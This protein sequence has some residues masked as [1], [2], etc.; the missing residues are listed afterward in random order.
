MA[1]QNT[2]ALRDLCV[3]SRS[4]TYGIVQPGK[5]HDGGVPIVRV[6]NFRGH[7][8]DLSDRLH[9]A[10][11]IEANYR[12]SR[13]KPGD[14]LISLVGSIGQVAI[15]P[16]DIEGWNLARA[17]GLVPMVDQATA[18]WVY[19]AL[20]TQDAQDYIRRHA[21]T[22]VQATFNLKDLARFPIP[23]PNRREREQ[24]L[25]VLGS[26]DDK[27]ELNR[28]MNE[29][30]ERIAQAIFRDWFVDFGPTQRKLDGV[31]D[32]VEIM[33]GLIAEPDRAREL[34]DLFPARLG[35]DGPPEGWRASAI[36]NLVREAQNGGTPSRKKNEFWETAQ[37]AWFK[38]GELN[39]Q[40]LL[41]SEEMISESGLR[42]IGNKIWPRGTIL[43][44]IYASPTVGRMGVLT[45]DASANQACTALLPK[46]E[47]GTA[48]LFEILKLC[49][50]T[51]QN[52]AVGAAQQNISQKMLLEHEVL[53]P[54]PELVAS[55]S[56]LATPLLDLRLANQKQTR[57][58]AAT[59]DLLLPKL[60]S[61]EI[62]LR[63]AEVE[64]EAAQ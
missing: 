54:T 20:Q 15:A 58:L 45:G 42:A 32:P 13:P 7:R 34:A 61:G 40:F 19:Y 21:N 60:M 6:N 5:L 39:D 4:I 1:D 24:V 38:T 12:R 23:F 62:R 64:L 51:L 35:D 16:P 31:T 55:F 22:T 11:E 28:R 25:E 49:R 59:R 41:Q 26:L 50:P 18:R 36:R 27:I 52:I 53:L 2:V 48:F 63:D 8:L 17:V 33:G 47:I 14:V 30:L 3:P 57:T 43:F 10:P 56:R 9:V 29:T 37:Y 46:P 44:A